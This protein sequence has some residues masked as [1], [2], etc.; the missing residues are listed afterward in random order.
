MNSTLQAGALVV[1]ALMSLAGP[2]IAFE[3]VAMEPIAPGGAS[4]AWLPSCPD[5][6]SAAYGC[7]STGM[8]LGGDRAGRF[9]V[10]ADFLLVRPTFS[11]AIAFARGVQTPTSLVTRQEALEFDHEPAFRIHGGYTR[12]T[13]QTDVDGVV[14]GPGSFIVDPFGAVV[15]QVTIIDP[16][17]ALFGQTLPGALGLP[18]ADRID[19]VAEVELNVF[20]VGLRREVPLQSQAWG[21]QWSAGARLAD[22]N[23]YYASR[24]SAGGVTISQGEYFVDFRGAGPRMGLTLERRGGLGAIFASGHGSMLLGSYDMTFGASPAP[25]FVAGQEQ[26]M[27]RMIPVTELEVGARVS[28]MSN[29]NLSAGYLFHSW[30]DLGTSGGRFA[31]LFTGQEDANIMSFDG[32]F[33]RGELSF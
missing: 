17:N 22:V 27:T 25:G 21:M 29:F 30:F 31:G 6:C 24:V 15:G 19:T 3:P 9:V 4:P 28:P 2:A 20:D 8:G 16:A 10:G 23:Q 26:H 14:N 13:A 18:V 12:I 7:G 5:G 1:F 11:E 32:L 33:A